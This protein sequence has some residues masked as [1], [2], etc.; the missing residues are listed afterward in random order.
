MGHGPRRTSASLWQGE[1]L[2]WKLR[3]RRLRMGHPYLNWHC[4][5][6][7][8]FSFFTQWTVWS[9]RVASHTIDQKILVFVGEFSA[10]LCNLLTRVRAHPETLCDYVEGPEWRKTIKLFVQGTSRLRICQAK[11]DFYYKG[12]EALDGPWTRGLEDWQIESPNACFE[13]WPNF[14]ID[15]PLRPKSPWETDALAPAS[16]ERQQKPLNFY[17]DICRRV[18]HKFT[19]TCPCSLQ[20][21]YF[22]SQHLVASNPGRYFLLGNSSRSIYSLVEA[23]CCSRSS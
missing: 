1:N 8:I 14:V 5:L 15:S 10:H 9:I 11:F 16:S 21:K 22:K 20:S 12:Q 3:C 2:K 13:R 19:N 23:N 7:T 4:L 6:P 17:T 18:Q